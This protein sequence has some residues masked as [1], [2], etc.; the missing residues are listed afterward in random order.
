MTWVAGQSGNPS[1]RP[2]RKLIQETIHAKFI[3]LDSTSG[4]PV[5]E[6]VVDAMIRAALQGNV[7]AFTA[8]SDRLEG[9]PVQQVAADEGGN[10]RLLE[11]FQTLIG[12]IKGLPSPG[13]DDG[14]E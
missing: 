14:E 8:L 2:K 13:G 9:K 4:R 1:G 11:S 12:A 5:V 7:N 3:A 6:A 10:D